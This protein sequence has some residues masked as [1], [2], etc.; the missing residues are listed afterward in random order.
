MTPIVVTPVAGA[1][2]GTPQRFQALREFWDRHWASVTICTLLL[3]FVLAYLSPNIFVSVYPGQAMILYNRFSPDPDPTTVY[4]E[5]FHI[6]APWNVAYKYDIRFQQMTVPIV[7]V[8]RNGLEI[9]VD[10]SVSFRPV[11]WLIPHLHRRYGEQYVSQLVIPQLRTAIQDIVGQLLP[12]EV[13]SMAR[14]SHNEQMFAKTQRV[15]GGVYVEIGDVSIV[16]VR[17]PPKIEDAIQEKLHEE[18]M[19]GLY[20]FKVEKEK[21]EAERKLE[22]AKGIAAFQQTVAGGITE[23]LLKWKGIEATVELA[24]SPNAK[25]VVVGNNS[26]QGLPLILGSDGSAKQ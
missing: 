22:E 19:V 3:V 4:G 24:K 26:S 15:V 23:P 10:C 12:E 21:K 13:Y 18:Q 2:S 1:A 17:L 7:A 16:N 9:S 8:A 6:V 20:T 25:V 11:F 14:S 5:G